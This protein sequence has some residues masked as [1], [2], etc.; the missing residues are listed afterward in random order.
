VEADPLSEG[1]E[2]L[3]SLLE[4]AA[5]L[6]AADEAE[7]AGEAEPLSDGLE[8]KEGD[9]VLVTLTSPVLLTVPEVDP[10]EDILG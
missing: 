2:E 4:G 1:D 3:L 8:D 5:L 6:E 10:D 7:G 9:D